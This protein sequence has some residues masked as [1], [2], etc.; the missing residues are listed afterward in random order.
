MNKL[1]GKFKNAVAWALRQIPLRK[2]TVN[3]QI[4]P[5]NE[6]LKGRSALIT[7]GSSGIGLATAKAFHNA[8]CN[9]VITGRNEERLEKACKSIKEDDGSASVK[10]IVMDVT[11]IE[12]LAHAF[13]S[14]EKKLGNRFDILVNNAGT[15][16]NGS[17][18]QSEFEQV[19][20]TNVEGAYF[21][22]KIFSEHIS[23][24]RKHGNILNILSSSSFRPATNPYAISKWGMR[25]LT[26]GLART[27]IKKDIVVN[28]IAPG[29]TATPMLQKEE[30]DNLVK[31]N[32]PIGRYILPE[33]IANMAVILVSDM[34][35]SA[36]G[37]I[38]CMTG[39]SGNVTNED[40]KF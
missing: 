1:I 10:Y 8:G 2:V 14:A 29:P 28:A 6:L 16:G 24:E 22:S 35:R 13:E 3:V 26:I 39:G 4:A 25:G 17:G 30:G 31:R 18:T 11:N 36:V 23:K 38:F 37:E 20:R 34:C 5:R 12:T 15:M 33:E 40:I 32:S 19:I 27:L 21:L 7:G 9:I